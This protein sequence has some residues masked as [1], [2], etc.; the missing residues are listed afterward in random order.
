[1]RGTT[2]AE[3]TGRRAARGLRR[4]L[5]GAMAGLI[6]AAMT[7]GLVT[8]DGFQEGDDDDRDGGRG[9]YAIGLWGDL[10]YS[11]VQALTGVPN[12]IADMY[13]QDRAFTAHDGHSEAGNTIGNSVTPSTCADAVYTPGLGFLR[14]LS[15]PALFAPGYN[16]WTGCD[17]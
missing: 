7:T 11:D 5:P 8:G 9:A 2:S 1:M 10:P 13:R 12:L 6:V 17:R 14:A 4:W 3:S 16:D 15:A